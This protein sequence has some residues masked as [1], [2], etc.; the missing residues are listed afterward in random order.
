MDDGAVL[1][2]SG[3]VVGAGFCSNLTNVRS[4]G[5]KFGHSLSRYRVNLPKQF[6]IERSWVQIPPSALGLGDL[7]HDLTKN[8]VKFASIQKHPFLN[9]K[10]SHNPQRFAFPAPA[11]SQILPQFARRCRSI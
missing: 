5:F 10:L 3:A 4:Q 7:E 2:L 8:C 6:V 9:S 11:V 1:V